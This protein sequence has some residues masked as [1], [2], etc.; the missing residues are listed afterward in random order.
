MTVHLVDWWKAPA[1]TAC[2]DGDTGSTDVASVDCVECLHAVLVDY[3]FVR[4]TEDLWTHPGEQSRAP[5]TV[6]R[7]WDGRTYRLRID[8]PGRPWVGDFDTLPSIVDE[9]GEM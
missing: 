3:G 8:Y 6:E 9:I 1:S 2:G 7:L 4:S 5:M